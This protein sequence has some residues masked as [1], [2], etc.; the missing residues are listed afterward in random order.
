MLIIMKAGASPEEIEN[1]ARRVREMG[2]VPHSIPGTTRTAIGITGN[3]PDLDPTP[4][5]SLPGVL[6]AIRVSKPYKL[7][8]RETKAEDTV[9]KVAARGIAI[10]GREL[11]IMAGPC[12]VENRDQ[13]FTAAEAVRRAGGKVLRGGA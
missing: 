11:V 8:S 3:P 9:V 6:Q 7:V 4:F 5:E 1:V 13:I 2:M 12:S 10:G